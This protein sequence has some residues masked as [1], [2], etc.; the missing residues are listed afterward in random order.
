MNLSQ[1]EELIRKKILTILGSDKQLISMAQVRLYTSTKENE[2]SEENITQNCDEWL[3]SNLEGNLCYVLDFNKKT[4]YLRLFQK[5]TFQLLFSMEIYQNFSNF[6]TQIDPFFHCFEINNAFIGLQFLELNSANNFLLMIKKLN[7]QIVKIM[8][9]SGS[10]KVKESRKEKKKKVSENCEIL[11]KNF[12]SEGKYGKEY[13][14]DCMEICKPIFYELLNFMSY[15]RESKEFEVGTVPKEF[16]NLFKNMGIKK[17]ML[18]KADTT[19]NFFKYFI[20]SLDKIENVSK[21]KHSSLSEEEDEEAEKDE[22][23]EAGE[24]NVVSEESNFGNGYCSTMYSEEKTVISGSGNMDDMQVL[25]YKVNNVVNENGN[26]NENFCENKNKD[27]AKDL[28][29]I[30]HG[31]KAD[32]PKAPPMPGKGIIPLAPKLN[33]VQPK[34]PKGNL[35]VKCFFIFFSYFSNFF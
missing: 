15:N 35:G 21:R 14:E 18:K 28:I 13:C 1:S 6:Y 11:K 20:E 23:G 19:L 22:A 33:L 32:M 10:M 25:N 31:C 4:R 29:E 2:N 27:Y 24:A 7:D 17:H 34:V 9:E 30:P 16:R 3:F 12:G 5:I 8:L 26:C